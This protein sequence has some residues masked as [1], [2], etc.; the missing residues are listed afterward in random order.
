MK[1]I[2]STLLVAATPLLA[3]ATDYTFTATSGDWNTQTNWSPNGKPGSG[4][5]AIIPNGK[6]CNIADANQ[7][8]KILNVQSGG[9]L[10]IDYDNNL[11][12]GENDASTTSTVDGEIHFIES[13]GDRAIL[14]IWGTV[15]FDGSGDIGKRGSGYGG[16]IKR[17][18]PDTGYY[19]LM[20][21]SDGVDLKGNLTFLTSLENNVNVTVS[22]S[23]DHLTLGGMARFIPELT[24]AGTGK[25]QVSNGG[26]L[27]IRAAKLSAT[28]PAWE[29]SGGEIEVFD[30]P[31]D[32]TFFTGLTVN[33]S[34]SGGTLD[35][36][37]SFGST[38]EFTF[39]GGSV[40]VRDGK[41]VTLD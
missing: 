5:T 9:T 16:L 35:L 25:F 8:V 17:A 32:N 15:T 21:L 38:G 14:R 1:R 40:I 36:K 24:L 23:D 30:L 26:F 10:V 39:T 29:L 7:A 41:T 28:T 34:V 37:D 22:H 20:I 19:M 4:D 3:A 13:A 6:T 2:L 27:E 12:L 31:Y 11:Q 33:I 18:D